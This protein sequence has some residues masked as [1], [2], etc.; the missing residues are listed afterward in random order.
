MMAIL[1]GEESSK[2]KKAAKKIYGSLYQINAL[3]TA[4]Q[5][6][7]IMAKSMLFFVFWNRIPPALDRT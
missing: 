2:Y 5:I 3:L 6:Y 7:L 4:A 1:E